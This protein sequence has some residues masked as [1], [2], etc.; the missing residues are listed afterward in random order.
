[1][2]K[3][4]VL[5]GATGLVGSS[6]L[7]LLLA[8][9]N[10]SKITAL[11]RKQQQWNHPK[12]TTAVVD[13]NK[14]ASWEHLL[15]GDDLFIC[16]GTTIK[17]AG[18][19][20][21][22]RAVDFDLPFELAKQARQNKMKQC[23]LVS[24]LGAATNSRFF[25]PR[26]KGELEQAIA[27]LKFE[28]TLLIQPSVLLGIRTESRPLEFISQGIM[29]EL[30]FLFIGPFYDYRAISGYQV[31]KAMLFYANKA[32]TGVH[33]IKGKALFKLN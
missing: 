33:R 12:L 25:Y 26:V 32:M 11:V 19:Q 16:T 27:D 15:K 8:D 7:T 29:R 31:A 14:Q 18:S 6:L 1:M 24:A 9:A 3:S 4:A 5:I 23:I 2:S 28:C 17:K 20:Q 21:A 22:F 13:F 30:R 10:Y